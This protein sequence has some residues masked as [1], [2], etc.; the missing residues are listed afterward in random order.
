MTKTNALLLAFCLL[1]GTT[2]AQ[3]SFTN[4]TNLLNGVYHSGGVVGVVDMNTDGFDDIIVFD[5]SN[6]IYVEYQNAN[7]SFTQ[8][9]FGVI[10]PL[11]Q[12]GAAIGEIDG[13]GHKDIFT[14]GR[15]DGASY[16]SISSSIQ[17]SSRTLDNGLLFMQCAN[18]ADMNN[19]GWLD[20]FGCHDD[21]ASKTWINDGAGALDS[22]TVIDFTTNPVSDMSG[23]YGS[24]WTDVDHDGDIDLYIAKCRQFVND[25]TDPRRINVLYINDGNGNFTDEAPARGVDFGAQSWSA[26][27]GDIDN[28]GDN[29]L[30]VTNHDNT[31]FLYE[32]NG[33]GYFTDITANSGIATAGFFLQSIMRDFDND[34]N[35]DL[36]LSGGLERLYMGN[37]D[38]TFNDNSSVIAHTDVLHSFG[39]GDLNA[40]GFIDIYASYGDT[41]VNPDF[42]NPDVLWLNEGNA[43]NWIALELAGTVSNPGAVGATTR[44]YGPWGIQ[45]R[46]IRAGESYGINNSHMAH[47]GL[48][49]EMMVDSVVINWP[50]GL[51]DTH[52][53]IAAGSYYTVV[54]GGCLGA[55]ALDITYNATAPFVCTGGSPL[56]LTANAASSYLWSTGDTTQSIS[57]STGGIY[58]VTITDAN[59]CTNYSTLSVQQDPG[60]DLEILSNSGLNVCEGDTIA[61]ST[62]ATGSV[63]W[64][65]GVNS[66]SIQVTQSSTI[67]A[68]TNGYCGV[69]SAQPLTLDFEPIPGAPVTTG[70][71]L[72]APGQGTVTATGSNIRWYDSQMG[73]QVV[74]IGSPWTTPLV[75]LAQSFWASD[76][77]YSGGTYFGAKNARETNAGTYFTDNNRW[78]FFD[79]HYPITLQSVKVFADGAGQRSI[80][81]VD[82]NT[83]ATVA[84]GDFDLL[85]GEQRVYLDF[86]VPGEGQY[87]IRST[88]STTELWRDGIGSSNAYPFAIDTLVTITSSNVG[89]NPTGYY[90]F[91]YDW[92]ILLDKS[93][94]GDRSEAVVE[95]VTS[96]DELVKNGFEL[97]PNP[98]STQINIRLG[99]SLNNGVLELT[100]LT[101][102]TVLTK[103]IERSMTANGILTLNLPELSKGQYVLNLLIDG[104]VIAEPLLL[105]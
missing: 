88:G 59:G 97:W 7:G 80:A 8:E 56:T 74:G 93:C 81:I 1:A 24:V 62:S 47:F 75:A 99:G 31:V 98:A 87:S 69:V 105:H 82:E 40:D 68:S 23:N 63:T 20:A 49:S 21:G 61:L 43:N 55:P 65:T 9:D 102:R 22:A 17:S 19:D 30:V 86:Y 64:T 73:G 76:I 85:D 35:L 90:Y 83:G 52:Y 77:V 54:E 50:S 60:E 48:G 94:E 66:Q 89:N 78:L 103:R 91:F 26:D 12:W 4:A 27:F 42:Q 104:R 72:I 84:S 13:D 6:H 14:G 37:G 5:E 34:G 57:L 96:I 39:L 95:V 100:D 70:D 11:V 67:G 51:V 2:S 46:E 45:T 44:I 25:P 92:E 79:V 18:L 15:Y 10:S 41:Y 36:L 3:V 28:D 38:G 16:L 32:N 29:D 53:N 58:S 71:Q 101:G 33:A